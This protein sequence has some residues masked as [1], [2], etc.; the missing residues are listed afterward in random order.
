M[1]ANEL[2][3]G[4]KFLKSEDVEAAG[5][6]MTLTI[7][8]VERKEYEDNGKKEVKGV[9]SFA[10]DD[11]Q[12]SLNVTNTNILIGMFGARNIDVAWLGKKITIY[13]DPNISFSGKIV[14]GLRI[15]NINAKE[16]ASQAFWAKVSESFLSPEEGRAILKENGGDFVKALAVLDGDFPQ[17]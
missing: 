6:E 14:K 1:D 11:H 10:D 13:V 17:V 5:G 7:S 4:G 16:A 3:N 9:L 15:R 12:L 2:F 8:K